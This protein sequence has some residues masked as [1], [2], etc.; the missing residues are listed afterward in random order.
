[1]ERA[2]ADD[3]RGKAYGLVLEDTRTKQSAFLSARIAQRVVRDAN[4][5]ALPNSRLGMALIGG[6]VI[7]VVMLGGAST[8]LIVCELWE[9]LTSGVEPAPADGPTETIAVG[10]VKV[11]ASGAF[12]RLDAAHV[13]FQGESVEA[14]DLAELLDAM[15]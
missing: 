11:L 7:P 15:E 5:S 14:L 12:H 6:Q 8:E 4:V 13:E 3:T 9:N 2:D 1:M 10:G